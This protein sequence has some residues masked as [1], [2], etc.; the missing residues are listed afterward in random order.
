VQ[1][2]GLA[3][4]VISIDWP[5]PDPV[6]QAQQENL[7]TNVYVEALRQLV[8]GMGVYQNEVGLQ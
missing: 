1:F 2:L 3:C 5:P 8:P 4:E 6:A 7:F